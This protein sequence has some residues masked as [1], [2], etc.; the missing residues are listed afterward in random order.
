MHVFS[1]PCGSA[2]QPGGI[3]TEALAR[4]PRTQSMCPNEIW[5]V[6]PEKLSGKTSQMTPLPCLPVPD[7][8]SSVAYFSLTEGTKA[9]NHLAQLSALHQHECRLRTAVLQNT[10]KIVA[11]NHDAWTREA[12]DK[13]RQARTPTC[14]PRLLHVHGPARTRPQQAPCDLP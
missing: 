4:S 6:W 5:A 3:Q 7:E 12:P 13:I 2:L 1:L 9:G 10:A 11:A 8:L 14:L